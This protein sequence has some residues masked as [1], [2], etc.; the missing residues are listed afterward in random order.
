MK[1]IIFSLLVITLTLGAVAT[2]AYALFSSQATVSGLTFSTGNADLKIYSS[3]TWGNDWDLNDS[4][5]KNLYPMSSVYQQFRLKNNSSSNISLALSA[6]LLDNPLI[7][8]TSWNVLKDKIEVSFQEYDGVSWESSPQ[9]LEYLPLSV[10]NNPGS[11]LG[12][13]LA[14]GVSN[15]YRMLVRIN[16]FDDP[17]NLLP[18]KSISGLTFQFTGT[19]Q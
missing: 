12:T 13:T 19:Q 5:F 9:I 17:N 11:E 15:Y 2:S 4:I 3:G 7:D 10:W 8:Q 14:P 6:K 1:I 18:N 16:D